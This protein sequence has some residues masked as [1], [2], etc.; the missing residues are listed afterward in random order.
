MDNATENPTAT[1]TEPQDPAETTQVQVPAGRVL[2]APHPKKKTK[3]E[4]T[5]DHVGAPYWGTPSQVEYL[6]G[7]VEDFAC[8]D[9]R[10]KDRKEIIKKI[11]ILFITKF[12]WD[13]ENN[14]E[15]EETDPDDSDMAELSKALEGSSNEETERRAEIL[16]AFRE[17]SLY[18]LS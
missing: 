6:K 11:S 15:D 1:A 16:T 10:S 8:T 7:F 9:S 13:W 14:E 17:V 12:G 5:Q 3:K 4:K 18:A 2:H